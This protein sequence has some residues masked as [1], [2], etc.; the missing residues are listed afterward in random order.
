MLK[1]FNKYNEKEKEYFLANMALT[2]M[3][4]VK[5]TAEPLISD[6]ER[7]FRQKFLEELYAKLRLEPD[8]NSV[9]SRAII[10]DFISRTLSKIALKN[11]DIN[12]IKDSIGDKGLLRN[13]SYK[14]VITPYTKKCIE[15][16]GLRAKYI[17]DAI[18]RP[19]IESHFQPG[20]PGITGNKSVSIYLKT[21]TSQ[22][23]AEIYSILVLSNR[24]GSTQNVVDAWPIY[25]SDVEI[26]N[27]QSA[28]EVLKVFID[29]Y[30]IK[31][32]FASKKTKFIFYDKISL[33]KDELDDLL[34]HKRDIR[35]IL[36]YDRD[37]YK[38]SRMD[39][40]FRFE[41]EPPSLSVAIAFI[42]NIEKLVNDLN[43]HGLRISV[44]IFQSGAEVR[45]WC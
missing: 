41:E 21:P 20:L 8:D 24:T 5:S 1:I 40:M 23:S 42:I 17:E 33:S 16:L 35:G 26:F 7:E 15:S 43:K 45:E 2:M 44:D 12:K 30:G 37:N 18:F 25:H 34:K 9:K 11:S 10:Y 22:K 4:H 3:P 14:I 19:D 28:L 31:F 13:D 6:K 27:C 36:R 29:K 32:E 39:F 38:Y